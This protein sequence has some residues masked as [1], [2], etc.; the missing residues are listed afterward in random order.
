MQ[1]ETIV[2]QNLMDNVNYT[3]YCGSDK[4]CYNPRTV[5]RPVDGQFICPHCKWISQ[6]PEDF[7][8]R[9]KAKHNLK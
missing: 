1:E 6:F 3:P 9:Y 5:Y 4:D 8:K 7:I 2:R